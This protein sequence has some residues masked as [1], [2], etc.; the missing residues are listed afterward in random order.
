MARVE[1]W[2]WRC[3]A[4]SHGKRWRHCGCSPRNPSENIR[5]INL[6]DEVVF[7]VLVV[8]TAVRR[9]VMVHG[10]QKNTQKT[11]KHELDKA[12][13]RMADVHSSVPTP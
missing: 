2:G 4:R 13:K 12:L 7:P 1:G 5:F 3:A 6:N 9:F 11:P 10:F 8:A